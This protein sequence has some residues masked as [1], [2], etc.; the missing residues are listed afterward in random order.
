M[1][2]LRLLHDPPTTRG[3]LTVFPG[4][5]RA[6]GAQATGAPGLGLDSEPETP[7]GRGRRAATVSPA[8]AHDA[9]LVRRFNAG[10]EGAFAEIIARHRGKMFAIALSVL[11]NHADAEEIAQ[12]T[13]IRAYRCL[14]RFRGES[15]LATWLHL[16]ALNLSRNRYWYFFRRHRHETRSFDCAAGDD[17]QANI[18]DLITSD[19]PDPAREA[20]NR[21]FCA[22]VTTCMA[23]LSA[24]QR[25]I[26]TLRNL[27]DQTYEEIA[28]SLG[29][30]LGTVK[31][32]IARARKNLRV[33][34]SQTYAGDEPG[35]A[36][37]FEWF[38]PS[39]P[40][41]QLSSVYG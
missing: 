33:L 10:D 29:L 22:H 2:R 26:L 13:F 36:P 15:S 38:E 4:R 11:R 19:V 17:G 27:L 28:E 30:S 6:A 7:A 1:E 41:G 35:T 18:A 25:E 12:D 8:A 16:I 21:E 20:A 34:L 9:E 32:R 14:A 31:S 23:K 24:H 39:R 5:R 40:S 3:G 37:S